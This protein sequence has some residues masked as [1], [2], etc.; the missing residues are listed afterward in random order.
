MERCGD[1]VFVMADDGRLLDVRETCVK[2]ELRISDHL[3]AGVDQAVADG[4]ARQW[5]GVQGVNDVVLV[6][7][8]RH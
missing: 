2:E 6:D 5:E 7:R 4:H 1:L 3:E 8:I